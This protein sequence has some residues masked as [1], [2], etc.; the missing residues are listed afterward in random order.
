MTKVVRFY[1]KFED[2]VEFSSKNFNVDY[3]DAEQ[4]LVVLQDIYSIVSPYKAVDDIYINE[5]IYDINGALQEEI[6][7]ASYFELVKS[8]HVIAYKIQNMKLETEN[9][10][11]IVNACL[12]EPALVKQYGIL[13]TDT[14]GNIECGT[15]A[16]I[17]IFAANWLIINY[18]NL[19]VDY[20]IQDII[21]LDNSL[22]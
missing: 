4:L 16:D 15:C 8:G 2:G 21:D 22:D 11:D 3:N 14:I 9:F 20:S 12:D 17:D 13:R 5:P 6:P 19:I 7:L 10:L 1:I 18:C